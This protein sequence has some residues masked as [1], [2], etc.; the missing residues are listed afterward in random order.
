M[1][2]HCVISIL[3]AFIIAG[4][5]SLASCSQNGDLFDD[6]NFVREY[7]W[8]DGTQVMGSPVADTNNPEA[9]AELSSQVVICEINA[10]ERAIVNGVGDLHFYYTATVKEILFDRDDALSVGDTI[11][12][13]SS[14][15]IIS[16]NTA[17][18]LYNNS[19]YS[20]KYGVLQ[21]TYAPNEFV[22]SS[23]DNAIPI[24]AGETYLMYLTDRYFLQEKVYAEN[25][26]QFLYL[27]QNNKV[28]T[29]RNGE[30]NSLTLGKLKQEVGAQMAA[31]TGRADEIGHS[32][33]L[34]EL[35]QKQQEAKKQA[36]K[37]TN[38]LD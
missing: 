25:G 18:A 19:A 7:G 36:E 21:G 30:K 9:V 14:E 38:N 24:Q 31:R 32:A 27:I 23:F 10:L 8:I 11:T 17:K 2:K 26:G 12:I 33:Y 3:I 35:G 20:Q 37:N 15:G 13:S 34:T 28:Y 1:R 29:G 5:I 4:T 16:A 22:R 6:T